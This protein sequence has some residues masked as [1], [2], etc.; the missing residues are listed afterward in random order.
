MSSQ[1][2]K[3]NLYPKYGVHH[4]SNGRIPAGEEFYSPSQPRDRGGRWSRMGGKGFTPN[5][6]GVEGR[7]EYRRVNKIN[8]RD[9]RSSYE[10]VVVD[11]SHRGRTARAYMSANT[12]DESALPAY[13]KLIREIDDQYDFITKKLGI[14]VEVVSD[15]PYPNVEDMMDDINNKTLKVMSTATTGSHPL[16]SDAQND[17]FRAVHDF[18]GHAATGRDFSRHGERA[19]YLSHASM[20]RD[21]DSVRALFTETEA[22]NAAL[23]ATGEFQEQKLTLLDDS[24]VFDGLVDS[25]PSSL[26]ASALV[27]ACY[28]AA[29]RPPT[30]GGTGGSLGKARPLPDVGINDIRVAYRPKHPDGNA[31]PGEVVWARVPFEDDPSQSKDRPVIVIGRAKNGNLVGLQLTSKGHHRASRSVGKGSWDSSGR[32][33]FVKFDRIVQIDGRNYRKEGAAMGQDQFAGI[34]YGLLKHNG[35][36]PRRPDAVA[37][38]AKLNT[39][40]VTALVAACYDASCRPPTSG[41]TGGSSKGIGRKGLSRVSGEFVRCNPSPC[42]TESIERSGSAERKALH[43]RIVDETLAKG[44]P[45][46]TMTILGGG[47]GAGKSTIAKLLNLNTGRATLNA[48]DVKERLPEYEKLVNAGD[49]TA[50]SFVHEESSMVVKQAQAEARSRG[51]GV[52]L[53]QVGSSPDKVAQQVTDY[54]DAGYTTVDAVFVTIPTSLAVERARSRGA[55][56]GRVVPE[57]VLKAAHRDVSKGFEQ[58][59]SDPRINNVKL[60]DNTGSTPSL[61]AEGSRGTLR[62]LDETLYQ[63]FLAKGDE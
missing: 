9:S 21:P 8:R 53:D 30:S 12:Y 24:L 57:S 48:D 22:Q 38:S 60:Y 10:N 39:M 63:Q 4:V 59:A 25:Q 50:A 47:G 46:P 61:I 41:G 45:P 32:E 3:D 6:L 27:A 19:A 2:D 55:R 15:D 1:A 7:S 52:V 26:A 31:D 51:I 43:K 13:R 20:M 62:V 40:K 16:F 29:C 44:N 34:V 35:V 28:S 18:F 11:P 17:K 23:I 36:K 33:S 58:I 14:K 42:V 5:R 56:S 37:A 54:L 49:P